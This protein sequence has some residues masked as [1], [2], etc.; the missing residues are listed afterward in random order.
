MV[1]DPNAFILQ[2]DGQDYPLRSQ[3]LKRQIDRVLLIPGMTQVNVYVRRDV[4]DALANDTV[5]NALYIMLLSGNEVIYG[6]E[7]RSKQA[8][9]MT[10]EVF[11][12]TMAQLP[13]DR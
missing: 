12:Y 3:L 10:H 6:D 5:Y 8:H 4:M 2:V 7:Q 9:V 13:S 1:Y 11:Q